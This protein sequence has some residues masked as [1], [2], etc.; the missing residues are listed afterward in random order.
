MLK[1]RVE[2]PEDQSEIFKITQQA[3]GQDLEARLV[4]LLRESDNYEK[5]LSLVAEKK[6]EMVGHILF[7]PISIEPAS[8]DFKAV[9]LGPLAV[10]PYLHKQGI[11]S[12]LI[13]RGINAC[14]SSGYRAIVVIGHPAYYPQFGFTRA[15][16]KGLETPVP[17]AEEA[18]MVLELVPD[19]L[20]GIQ[21][22]IIFPQEFYEIEGLF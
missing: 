3:F 8:E 12:A 5:K 20:N 18:F 6:G 1:I 13:A 22:K 7:T 10:K 16:A 21:G 4:D 11:G 2:T 14:R 17:T 9:I 15:G 19:A